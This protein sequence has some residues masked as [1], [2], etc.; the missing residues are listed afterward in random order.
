MD[1][2]KIRMGL[3]ASLG[4]QARKQRLAKG[5]QKYQTGNPQLDAASAMQDEAAEGV[6]MPAVE[7]LD[8]SDV[9]SGAAGTGEAIAAAAEL[10]DEDEEMA[11]WMAKQKG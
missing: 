6:E 10:E 5:R 3:M 11:K 8:V 4:Q 7:A 2:N 9:D 1:R